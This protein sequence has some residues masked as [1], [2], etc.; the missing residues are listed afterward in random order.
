MN[1]QGQIDHGAGASSAEPPPK[2]AAAPPGAPGKKPRDLRLDFF[3]GIAMFIILCAHIPGNTWTLWIPARFGFS[4]ATEIFVFCSGFASSLAF[5]ALFLKRGFVPGMARIAW[6]V[7][8]VY[9]AHIGIFLVSATI[10]F[11]IQHH[12]VGSP[13]VNYLFRP[14]TEA[15]FSNTG[16]A[17]MGLLTLTWITGL[18]D[19]L[20]MYLVILAMIPVVMLVHR[21][22]GRAG[23]A[24]FVVGLW[25][26]ANLAGLAR[27]AGRGDESI[28]GIWAMLA[29]L[30]EPFLF[31]NLPGS[32]NPGGTQTWFFNPFGWQ[33][34]FFTGFAFGIGWLPAPPVRRWL[35]WTAIAVLL[36]S[37]PF[38]WH[39]LYAWMTGYWPGDWGGAVFWDTRAVLKPL[40]WK[41]WQGGLR[42]VHFLAL[43][44]LA[45]VIVGPGGV[46]LTTGFR[47]PGAPGRRVCWVLGAVALLTVPYAYVEEIHWALPALDRFFVQTIPLVGAR[48]IGL[49]QIAHLVCL[50]LL[51]WSALGPQRRAASTTT[52]FLRTVPIVRKVG[53]QS[54]AVFVVSIPMAIICGWMLD[55]MDRS[56][57]TVASV[58]LGG[59]LILIATAYIAG[60]FRAQP[61]R[62][63]PARPAANPSG[64][65]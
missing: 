65:G 3:R 40:W 1:V 16:V 38:A 13:D 17:L 54:L 31:L 39:K 20:P 52:G 27:L 30:G 2:P 11:A 29:P 28:V 57:L 21:V 41:T 61:W 58:N 19:I 60:W 5:G 23:V 43:A 56:M 44:Y 32:P 63:R 50:V 22:S 47:A 62:E 33:L 18:F 42:F 45:W 7:W 6:R 15:L 51:A 34:V 9:W 48:W 53:T 14:Y 25:V 12:G 55:L 8:Q 35:I 37:M 59:F 36:L 46:K 4:D 10:A 24:I 64:A 26:L 49:L